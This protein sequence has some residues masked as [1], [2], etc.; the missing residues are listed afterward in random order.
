MSAP[1]AAIFGC[2]GYRLDAD[3]RAFL[4]DA[5]PWGFI[6]FARN[7]ADREQL[8]ALVAELREAVGRHAPVLVDQEG[9][10]VARLR[11]P[12]WREWE[13][14]GDL[15]ARLSGDR[16]AT[17]LRLRYRLIAAELAEVGIDVNCVPLLDV[18]AETVAPFLRARALGREA[19][20]VARLG[21]A[22]REGLEAGGVAPVIKHLP[23]HGRGDADSHVGLPVADAPLDDLRAA[24]FAP[25]RAH[26]DA[27]MGMT[28]HVVYP[29]LDP[30]TPGTLSPAVIRAIREE[31][32]FAGLL[33]TDDISMGALSGPIA[34]RGAR[35][36]AAG[37]DLVLHC[38]G[39]AADMRALAAALP[40]LEDEALRRARAAES[41][42]RASLFDAAEAEAKLAEL[43][44]APLPRAAAG[45]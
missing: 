30:E 21:R 32:G 3:E 36:L 8:R 5:D 13:N 9:G 10:R 40:R 20:T 38:D 22:V 16:A 43:G 25:F 28:A 37:C 18:L 24:D 2:A 6:L 17:A 29:A 11:G 35:A 31:I 26:A 7:V 41:R 1:L 19:E 45:A 44:A 14:V 42:S 15:V 12:I 33:M 23:G 34:E 27:P 39:D 4:R